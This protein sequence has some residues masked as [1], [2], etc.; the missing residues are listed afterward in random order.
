MGTCGFYKTN[1]STTKIIILELLVR[2]ILVFRSKMNFVHRFFCHF[3]FFQRLNEMKRQKQPTLP[4]AHTDKH[5]T[6]PN[7]KK[8]PHTFLV[9]EKQ[10]FV[11]FF[12]Y[13]SLFISMYF[14]FCFFSFVHLNRMC[15]F[16]F[17]VF[18]TFYIWRKYL[19]EA[20]TQIHISRKRK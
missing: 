10:V 8:N 13:F 1:F 6:N 18:F 16:F 15:A 2:I 5:F 7:R 3:D 4:V 19:T 20:R 14:F 11:N 12:L 17:F 9:E